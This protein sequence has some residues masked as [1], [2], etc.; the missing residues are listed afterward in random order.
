M[1]SR[2]V[3]AQA[4][5]QATKKDS[6]YEEFATQNNTIIQNSYF[7]NINTIEKGNELPKNQIIKMKQDS[8]E[9][10][11]KVREQKRKITRAIPVELKRKVWKRDNGRCQY[12]DPIT[13]KRCGST[14]K[15]E[16]EHAKPW[17]L[18][19]EHSLENLWILCR[20]HNIYRWDNIV[21]NN[22]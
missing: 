15:L 13:G 21:K 3:E 5:V 6:D 7:T 14:H 12:Q 10:L 2:C 16:F 19:G 9:Q 4:F 1:K 20:S 18:G 11:H 8:H 17:S 22:R